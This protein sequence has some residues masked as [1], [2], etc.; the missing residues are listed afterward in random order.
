MTRAPNRFQVYHDILESAE[1]VRISGKVKQVIGLVIES[2][3]PTCSIGDLCI[4]EEDG[5]E[6]GQA[7]VVGFRSETTLLMP[8]GSMEGIR[9]GLTVVATGKPLPV[10]VSEHLLG[11]ILDGLGNPIDD[12]GPLG[13]A[14][15]LPTF[16][17][18]PNPM[19]RQR[20]CQPMETGIRVIDGLTTIGKGQRIG[21]FSGSGVGKSVLMGM[22][23]RNCHADVTVIALIG[24]RGREVREFIE[25]D[26][27]PEGLRK[28]V[29]VVAT[30]EQPALI[31][32]KG[33]LVASTI[34]EYFRGRGKNVMLLMDSV[35]R[36]AMA[37]REIGLAIG[38]PPATKGYT[39]SVF[40]MIPKVLERAGMDE[41]GSITGLYTVLVEGDDLEEPVADSVRSVLDG[42]I[43]L[44]RKLANQN[45]YPA[46]DAL[47]SISRC[48]PDVISPEHKAAAGE[49]ISVMA[50]YRES[51]DLIN[52]GA[53]ARGSNPA[54]DR[55][56]AVMGKAK[57][58]LRQAVGERSDM[59][60]T[61]A[62]LKEAISQG[63]A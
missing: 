53:Y 16:R 55:A 15:R 57:L 7:E 40:A 11:R 52:I 56:I 14:E 31:R 27:G 48:M 3:G 45:H 12:K 22:I 21:I 36:M 49:L 38:E 54:V 59:A 10:N 58:F 47:A 8:L 9:P 46:V 29:V 25:K 28:A 33:A 39:P 50:T 51:E 62:M 26:L 6:V 30:S 32:L 61:L 41:H 35:T 34:A 4:L 42:H 63:K 18:A 5:K 20:I 19:R 2:S 13:A 23:S 44:S 17:R 37:Q 43:V 1:A 24:E 60:A